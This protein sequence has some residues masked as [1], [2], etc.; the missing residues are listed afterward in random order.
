[1]LGGTIQYTPLGRVGLSAECGEGMRQ[2]GSRE[3]GDEPAVW[4]EMQDGGGPGRVYRGPYCCMY[5]MRDYVTSD[6]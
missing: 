5:P 1:M 3:I 2:G 6:M 4:T